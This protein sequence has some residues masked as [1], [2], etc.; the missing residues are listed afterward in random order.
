MFTQNINA[1]KVA[2][3]LYTFIGNLRIAQDYDLNIKG[4]KPN[5]LPIWKLMAEK[6]IE[7]VQPFY[8][9]YA[10]SDL[11]AVMFMQSCLYQGKELALARQI[12]QV[13]EFFEA[14]GLYPN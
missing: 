10:I 9:D 4:F 5:S 14:K 13:L 1:L 8:K 12:Y 7:I 6:E 2:V 3:T 11:N